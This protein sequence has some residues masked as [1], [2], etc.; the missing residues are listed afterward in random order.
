[1]G[2][3]LF[4][5]PV[6]MHRI[7]ICSFFPLPIAKSFQDK[8]FVFIA[9]DTASAKSLRRL[10]D[11]KGDINFCFV[12]LKIFNVS[13]F[14]VL[15]Q[16][17][18]IYIFKGYKILLWDTKSFWPSLKAIIPNMNKLSKAVN[19]CN[20]EEDMWTYLKNSNATSVSGEILQF[21]FIRKNL[22]CKKLLISRFFLNVFFRC[23][24]IRRFIF[25]YPIHRYNV[26]DL[27]TVR[28]FFDFVFFIFWGGGIF[29]DF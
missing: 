29:D 27:I 24:S 2:L 12:P 10:V 13:Q 23:L 11:L 3:M 22:T 21:F 8:P 26:G 5:Q 20:N 28:K 17:L 18:F 4:L 9:L 16:C 1:M 25:K 7:I 14:P 19:N 15:S 6:L